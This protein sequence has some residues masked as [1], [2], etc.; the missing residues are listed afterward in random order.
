MFA[1]IDDDRAT[2]RHK[3]GRNLLADPRSTAGD[4]RN[5]ILEAPSYSL[6]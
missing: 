1:A 4:D 5:L 6:V 3:A 2:F